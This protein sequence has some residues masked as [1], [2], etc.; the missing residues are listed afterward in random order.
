MDCHRLLGLTLKKLG[1]AAVAILA[2]ALLMTCNDPKPASVP[3]SAAAL[4][5]EAVVAEVKKGMALRTSYRVKGAVSLTFATSGEHQ[6]MILQGDFSKP[7][8]LEWE[9]SGLRPDVREYFVLIGSQTYQRE[10]IISRREWSDWSET[11]INPMLTGG[12]LDLTVGLI[13]HLSSVS[14]KSATLETG[15]AIRLIGANS[16]SVLTPNGVEF[17]YDKNYDLRVTKGTYLLEELHLRITIEQDQVLLTTQEASYE[18]TG[19]D[20]PIKIET[21]IP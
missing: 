1:R 8:R 9:I 15:N 10:R 12:L 4:D 19:Y 7:D 14:W 2:A 17:R 3:H 13:D 11:K 20:Y 18:F 6:E 16:D 21:P 5:P